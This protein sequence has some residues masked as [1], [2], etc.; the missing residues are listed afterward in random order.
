VADPPEAGP[1]DD[2]TEAP[3]DEDAATPEADAAAADAEAAAVAGD[4][5]APASEAMAL[6]ADDEEQND[7]EPPFIEDLAVAAG[8]PA[9]SPMI[10]AVITDDWSGVDEAHVFYRLTGESSWERAPLQPGS[11]G[12]FVARLPDGSQRSGFEYYLEVWDAARNGPTRIGGPE[13]PFGI[14][15]ATEGTL[16][17]VKREKEEAE[18]GAVHPAWITLALGTGIA[19]TAAAGAFA[20][21]YVGLQQRLDNAAPNENVDAIRSAQTGDIVF[22]AILGA[23][24]VAGLATGISM[25]VYSAIA[26]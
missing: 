18:L 16:D 15:P 14:A 3:P 1:A 23:V 11:A 12:L 17:R 21:D 2:A 19:G 10:T 13:E 4:A 24:G 5:S 9:T 20:L 7:T 22:G 26:E 8:N 25:L 6:P